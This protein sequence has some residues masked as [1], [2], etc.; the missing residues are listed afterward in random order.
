MAG[1]GAGRE[2]LEGGALG[3]QADGNTALRDVALDLA[4]RADGGG[5]LLH[6]V[7]LGALVVGKG[8][9]ADDI[10]LRAEEAVALGELGDLNALGAKAAVVIRR[11]E[12]LGVGIQSQRD[13][14]G[15]EGSA[16]VGNGGDA[17][18]AAFGGSA[19]LV[20]DAGV[21]ALGANA[22]LVQSSTDVDA[23]DVKALNGG[24][25]VESLVGDVDDEAEAS[26]LLDGRVVGDHVEGRGSS[27]ADKAKKSSSRDKHLEDCCWFVLVVGV[28][29]GDLCGFV[30]VSCQACWMKNRFLVQRWAKL[31]DY[32]AVCESPRS[33]DV[34][35][36]GSS[37][38]LVCA[39]LSLFLLR[40][41]IATSSQGSSF[42]SP[43]ANI[44]ITPHN[45]PKAQ[46]HRA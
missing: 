10:G 38:V 2:V 37:F 45:S 39:V 18:E 26:G 33:S 17:V 4:G 14:V 23:V 8:H 41:G 28:C 25:E 13:A 35:S 19:V 3:E 29:V 20:E 31:A 42:P 12:S 11:G 21:L 40:T 34:I 43:T 44:P 27:G 24:R 30:G 32:I 15:R 16:L 7:E 36:P 1:V 9:V 22:D 6:D 5:G 46:R